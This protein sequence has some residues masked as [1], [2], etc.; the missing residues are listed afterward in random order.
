MAH[1]CMHAADVD[2]VS[3]ESHMFYASEDLETNMSGKESTGMLCPARASDR[4]NAASNH[5]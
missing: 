5:C 4:E 2:C 1:G 3:P